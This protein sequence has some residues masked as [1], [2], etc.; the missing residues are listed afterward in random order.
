MKVR[1]LID[2]LYKL[3]PN[4]IVVRAGYEGGVAEATIVALR[5]INLHVNDDWYY[6]PHEL[7]IK[8]TPG[9]VAA[10]FIN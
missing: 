7:T 4:A 1:E 2:E 10:V 9:D 3:P 5:E 6:G 8:N